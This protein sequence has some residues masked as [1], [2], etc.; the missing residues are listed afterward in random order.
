M[1]LFTFYTGAVEN[2]LFMMILSD[3]EN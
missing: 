3:H 2:F 1:L